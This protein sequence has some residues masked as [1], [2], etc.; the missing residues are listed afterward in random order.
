[1]MN[2]LSAMWRRMRGS[3]DG[4]AAVEFAII[5]PVLVL[6]GIT[7]VDLGVALYQR[8]TIDHVLR[9]G[10]QLAMV[11]PGEQAVQDALQATGTKNFGPNEVAPA[12]STATSDTTI[13]TGP[14]KLRLTAQ[15]YCA[16]PE[17]VGTAV[18]CSTV[19]TGT[20]PTYIYYRLQRT[21]GFKGMLLGPTFQSASGKEITLSSTMEVQVR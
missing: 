14:S 20:V 4:A 2:R 21:K 1:M 18:A 7:A 11:D 9:S 5:A 16:C 12:G 6:S 10:A 13:H 8:M 17:A 15:R 19:C 3:D